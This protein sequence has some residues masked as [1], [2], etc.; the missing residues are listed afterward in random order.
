LRSVIS[1]KAK[2]NP[3]ADAGREKYRK[4]GQ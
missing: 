1:V 4:A 3:N 2:V